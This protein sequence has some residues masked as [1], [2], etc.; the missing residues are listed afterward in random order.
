ME[1]EIIVMRYLLDEIEAFY[2]ESKK[3]NE[4]E[5]KWKDYENENK[6][7]KW[8]EKTKFFRNNGVD[9]YKDA[10]KGSIKPQAMMLRKIAKKLY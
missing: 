2:I 7:V 8:D 1:K 9:L 4:V 10:P 6:P 5:Q 3:Y